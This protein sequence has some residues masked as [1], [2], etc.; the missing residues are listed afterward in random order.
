MKVSCSVEMEFEPRCGHHNCDCPAELCIVSADGLAW[1]TPQ[2][3]EVE[4]G[5]V[6]GLP[7]GW[8]SSD[9]DGPALEHLHDALVAA[10][11]R[12]EAVRAGIADELKR[13]AG[14]LRRSMDFT[15]DPTLPQEARPH[16]HLGAIQFAVSVA[17]K[18]LEELAKEVA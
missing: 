2:G 14:V 5:Q 9:L 16:E 8:A 6:S 15:P 18:R 11:D 12:A 7:E 1:E 10:A 13:I 4:L 17:R 3:W